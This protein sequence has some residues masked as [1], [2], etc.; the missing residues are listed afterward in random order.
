MRIC[1]PVPCFFGKMDF[2][3]AIAKIAQLGFDA[4]ET[5]NWKSLDL[6]AVRNACEQSGVELLSMCTTEFNMTN[7]AKRE[8][9]LNGLK[10]SCAA[11]K[12]VGASKL[13]TQVGA[14][15]GEE[16]ARQHDSIVA[17][18]KQ[19]KP[20]L[21]D[22]GV[23]IMIEPL[24]I[25]VNHPGY[26]LWSSREAFE[27]IHEVDHPLVKVVYDIYHQQVMEG[28]IIPSIT[29]NLDCIAHLHSAGH[30]GRHELQFGENDYKV[31]FAAVDKAGYTGACG[32]EYGPTMDSVE[33]LKEFRR[34]YL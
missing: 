5:Y 31:I 11:A 26:Y 12:R 7:P 28:N 18:L 24:N 21:E 10:E 16:R 23:T 3:E 27:I 22:S 17:A 8:D 19:A 25:Y 14:D 13:I 4:A 15:T 30:P 2:C 6:D 20:I 29:Q 9:W 1:I 32:L 33:S 34:I